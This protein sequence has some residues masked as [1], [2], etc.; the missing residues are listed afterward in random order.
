M[1]KGNRALLVY[2]LCFPIRPFHIV[3]VGGSFEEISNQITCEGHLLA[4]FQ[5]HTGII[6]TPYI[7]IIWCFRCFSRRLARIMQNS[8]AVCEFFLHAS[9]DAGVECQVSVPKIA[10]T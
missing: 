6:P 8:G 2:N 3:V 9:N 4:H 1:N 5:S 7:C 10:A